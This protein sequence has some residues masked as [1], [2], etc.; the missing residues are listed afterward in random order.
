MGV[1]WEETT[2]DYLDTHKP[3]GV[4][5]TGRT[6]RAASRL[7]EKPA[8]TTIEVMTAQLNREL[9]PGYTVD[10]EI[11]HGA[12]FFFCVSIQTGATK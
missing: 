8:D 1:T 5:G 7:T 12:N 10:S 4:I 6:L 3:D 2:Q 9:M 11:I